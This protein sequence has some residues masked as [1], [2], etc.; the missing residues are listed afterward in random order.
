MAAE[1]LFMSSSKA[2]IFA[3]SVSAIPWA[4]GLAWRPLPKF[5]T[6]YDQAIKNNQYPDSH[7]FI[8]VRKK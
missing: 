8:L 3:L 7:N 5:R 4:T 6:A 1:I 2:A